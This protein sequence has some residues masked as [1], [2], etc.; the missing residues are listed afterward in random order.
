[1][2]SQCHASHHGPSV[3]HIDGWGAVEEGAAWNVCSS[4]GGRAGAGHS[5]AGP[6]RQACDTHLLPPSQAHPKVLTTRGDHQPLS[7]S[8]DLD[9][10]QSQPP[11]KGPNP[12]APDKEWAFKK[13]GRGE[14]EMSGAFPVAE[15]SLTMSAV[16]QSKYFK[17]CLLRF[18]YLCDL[19]YMPTLISMHPHKTSTFI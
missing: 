15:F 8:Y 11:A 14:G 4:V 19:W 2:S 17:R 5:T 16:F 12:A 9:R 10:A 18:I 7:D 6:H 3:L 13:Q 1:M